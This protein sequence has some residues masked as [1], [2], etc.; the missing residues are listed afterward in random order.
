MVNPWVV[1]AGT[2]NSLEV[3]DD[4]A[5]IVAYAEA[6]PSTW[7]LI[8]AAGFGRTGVIRRDVLKGQRLS[9]SNG[10]MYYFAAHHTAPRLG[11]ADMVAMFNHSDPPSPEF[12]PTAGGF[13][14]TVKELETALNDARNMRANQAANADLIV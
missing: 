5:A 2:F 8:G 12:D 9:D 3:A 6:N 11:R 10:D 13:K 4:T 1:T 7:M 14:W